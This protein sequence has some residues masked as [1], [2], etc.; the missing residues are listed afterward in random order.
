[1]QFVRNC[2]NLKSD[3]DILVLIIKLLEPFTLS[4]WRYWYF[5]YSSNR[6]PHIWKYFYL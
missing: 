2:S 4:H 5:F 6:R 3:K 1:M